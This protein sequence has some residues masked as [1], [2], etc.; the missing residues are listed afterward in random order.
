VKSLFWKFFWVLLFALM[1]D[2]TIVGLTIELVNQGQLPILTD[3][4]PTDC[5]EL[6]HHHRPSPL[7]PIT[8]GTI[9][10]L[11]FGA[12]LARYFTKPIHTLRDAFHILGQGNLAVRVAS[13]MGNRH[14]ELTDLGRDFDKMATQIGSLV[15]AQQRLLHDVSHE[16]RS[17]LARMQAAIGIA[18]QQPEET[19]DN[20]KRIEM[21]SQRISDLIGE[22]LVLSRLETG[23]ADRQ[24]EDIDI[25][26]LLEDIVENG[27]FEA[28]QKQVHIEYS[29][30]ETINVP[31]YSELVYRAVENILRNAVQHSKPENNIFVSAFYD[32]A[33]EC[34]Q[35][36]IDD[37]GPGVE[38]KYLQDIFQPFFRSKQSKKGNGVGLGLT[39]AHR[40]VA[41][42]GGQINA[43]NRPEG[44][45]HVEISIPFFNLFSK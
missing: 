31:G 16:L 34:L 26:S 36:S 2:V 10:S 37:Q 22:L 24:V 12:L 21:E 20:L 4:I 39:I 9:T 44:G 8:A 29:G 11:I 41:A 32:D 14:D 42:H 38:E 1:I 6:L 30:I 25:A 40:A 18:Q 23:V 43:Q 27:R 35:I 13:S 15:T 5:E 33:K 17:P 7:L 28:K 45:L 3:F 19:P